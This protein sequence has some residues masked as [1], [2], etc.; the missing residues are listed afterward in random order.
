MAQ[1]S[2]LACA[3]LATL[4]AAAAFGVG[5]Q[6][7]TAPAA[8]P[9]AAKDKAVVEGAFT[10]ADSDGDGKLTKEEAARLPSVGTKFEELDKD[11]DGNL[12]LQEFGTGFVGAS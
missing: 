10:R 4:L 2:L 5:A 9:P 11:K 1:R 3:S 7:S 12:N 6:T 8:E